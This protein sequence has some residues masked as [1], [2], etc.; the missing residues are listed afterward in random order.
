[1]HFGEG[2][3]V[4]GRFG[5]DE[6]NGRQGQQGG[7]GLGGK[8][9]PDFARQRSPYAVDRIGLEEYLRRKHAQAQ[10]IV[11]TRPPEAGTHLGAR[12]SGFRRRGQLHAGCGPS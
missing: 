11:G 6:G 1:M 10:R 12:S 8:L 7:H 2:Y 3:Q 4:A 5:D 9:L